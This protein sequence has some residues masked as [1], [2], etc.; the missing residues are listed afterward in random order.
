VRRELLSVTGAEGIGPYTLLRVARG[1]L[2]AGVPGQFFMLEAPGR[3][4]PRPMSLCSA[5]PRELTFL[6]DPIGPGT[7]A[8]CSLGSRDKL[9]IL[10]PLGNGFDLEVE[11]PLLVGGGI[12][13]APLPRLSEALGGPPAVLGF[14]SDWHAEAAAL[15]PNA[16]TCI[17]PILVTKLLPEERHDVLACGP[18]PMLEAVRSL[19]PA[20]QLAW[21]APMACGYGA[22]HGCAVE[23]GGE[24]RRLCVEGPVLRRG[25]TE[26]GGTRGSPVSPLLRRAGS[27]DRAGAPV[28]VLVQMHR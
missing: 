7:R 9:H 13:V 11:R 3:V 23:I 26:H 16:E 14:R 15:V 20:A 22:C 24:L 12:G 25:G 8:L 17:E 27:T 2:D 19:A 21:E 18:A 10:G 28:S 1:R 4:L 6:I 5:S